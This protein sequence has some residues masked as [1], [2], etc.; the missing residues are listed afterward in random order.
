VS[1]GGLARVVGRVSS[2][3]EVGADVVH[4]R[5]PMFV[6]RADVG[7]LEKRGVCNQ[8]QNIVVVCVFQRRRVNNK[9]P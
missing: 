7:I 9:N 1:L 2:G 6:G 8:L 3:S 4:L 5:A